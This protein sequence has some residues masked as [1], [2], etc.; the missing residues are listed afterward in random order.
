[1]PSKSARF[2]AAP[3]ETL[4]RSAGAQVVSAELLGQ[5]LIAVDDAQA[6]PHLRLRR[7]SPSPLAHRLEKNGW[8][9]ELLVDMGHFLLRNSP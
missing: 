8:L 9:W 1:M 5:F 2:E 4:A 7:E 3:L 6:S